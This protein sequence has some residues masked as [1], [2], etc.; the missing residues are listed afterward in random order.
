MYRI[1]A[2][3]LQLRQ[4][5]SVVVD[6]MLRT[7]LP[8]PVGRGRAGGGG[9]HLEARMAGQLDRHRSDAARTADHQQVLAGMTT[10][11]QLQRH[12]LE[13]QFP[14]GER[15]QRQG[16]RFSEI[17]RGRLACDQAFIHP[18]V[19]RI[20]ARAG[21]IAGVIDLV[22]GGEQAGLFA[23]CFDHAGCV[24]TEHAGRL[25]RGRISGRALL[26][27]DGVDR[28]CFDPDQQVTTAWRQGWGQLDIAQCGGGFTTQGDSFHLG[29]GWVR[30]LIIR[31]LTFLQ[32]R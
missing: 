1:D 2:Q 13:Q 24:P 18:L 27:I 31:F 29:S 12:A 4:Q 20:A 28:D 17:Q 22:A 11:I 23:D 9:D 32:A 26:A 3:R 14:G 25:E 6:H 5:R 16:G 7:H 21:D 10:V 15:G 19:L 8:A 30:G